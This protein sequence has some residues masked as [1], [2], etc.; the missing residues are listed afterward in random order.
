MSFKSY[1]RF[2]NR[3]PI[4]RKLTV[5]FLSLFITVLSTWGQSTNLTHGPILGALTDTSIKVFCRT[6]QAASVNVMY[7]K[8]A[9]TEV[10]ASGMVNTIATN[11]FTA[12]ISLSDLLPNTSYDY[13]IVVDGVTAATSTFTTLPT[14]DQ[15]AR[16]SFSVGADLLDM[17]FTIMNSVDAKNP[18]FNLLIGDTVYADAGIAAVT[19]DDFRGKYKMNFGESN[20]ANFFRKCPTFFTWDDH[21]IQNNWDKGAVGLYIPA[22]Q[23]YNEYVNAIN[24][25][26][27]TTGNLYYSFKAGQAEF[28]VFDTRTYRSRNN[29]TDNSTKTMLG[30][31]QKADFKYWLLNSTAKFKI[32]ISSVPFSDF[33]T[34]SNDSW[35]GFQTEKAELLNFINANS[36]KGV[37][38]ITGDQHFSMA[39]RLNNV[40]PKYNLYEFLP[41]PLATQTRTAPATLDSQLLFRQDKKFNYGFFTIDTT[42]T[43][44]TLTYINYDSTNNPLYQLTI[45]E[46][47]I[48]PTTTASPPPPVPEVIL[49]NS[50]TGSVSIF[51]DW[52][53]VTSVLGPYN[54]NY[55]HDGNTNKGPKSVKYTPTIPST[56][57][58]DV[59]VRWPSAA[60]NANNTRVVLLSQGGGVTYSV[61]Q[62]IQNNTWVKLGT[63]TF[64]EGALGYVMIKNES[65]TGYV[66]ADAVKFTPYSSFGDGVP[67]SWKRSYWGWN[68]ATDT[69]SVGI[70][71][72]DGDGMNNLAEFMA[73]TSPVDRSSK[74]EI[75]SA[76]PDGSN[77][78]VQWPCIGGMSYDVEWTTNFSQWTWADRVSPPSTGTASWTDDGSRIDGIQPGDAMRRF[79]RVKI[80]N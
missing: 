59:Y 78:V 21:E 13:Q 27:R 14:T 3:V 57:V 71:D 33:G 5:S 63:H 4:M 32:V 54:F 20:L 41:T 9:D 2:S 29:A 66:I 75:T 38:F 40:G 18:A 15:P 77:F 16:F 7:K 11:D 17:P 69:A 10:A 67:D 60:N 6:S 8:G 76:A 53:Q 80:P 26:S 79:Y 48:N 72:P 49:D 64:V 73:G 35:I 39:A 37:L 61:N 22:R 58:Y 56:G 30:T 47:D 1:L 31:V 12:T 25:S 74:V 68:F 42:V 34:T 43:P 52:T 19:L 65:T 46:T 28:Y 36:I 23:A 62:Q 70:A 44:A 50:T 55:L 51:G 45:N 24:P